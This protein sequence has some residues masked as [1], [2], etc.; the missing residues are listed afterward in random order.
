MTDRPAA[1]CPVGVARRLL[2]GVI[3]MFLGAFAISMLP[4][5][6]VIAISAGTLSVAVAFSAVTERRPIGLL[7]FRHRPRVP[8]D[9]LG[10]HDTSGQLDLVQ[11]LTRPTGSGVHG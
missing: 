10:F 1:S 6:P 7:A 11:T 2:R 8:L 3:S 5:D 4:S 9:T